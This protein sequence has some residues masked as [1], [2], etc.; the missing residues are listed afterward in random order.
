MWAPHSHFAYDDGHPLFDAPCKSI[1]TCTNKIHQ[2]DT[3]HDLTSLSAPNTSCGTRLLLIMTSFSFNF[4][5]T[6]P[7][8][9]LP[10][11]AFVI[12]HSHLLHKE[13]KT[14]AN[15]ENHNVHIPDILYTCGPH[16]VTLPTRMGILY[17]M[18]HARVYTHAQI[19]FT[20][21]SLT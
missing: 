8:V 6:L 13:G 11:D 17:L 7:C 10:Q 1:Y 14:F 20:K 4:L 3:A 18:R 19:N 9:K 5:H 2:S 16:I 15:S 12:D 21:K